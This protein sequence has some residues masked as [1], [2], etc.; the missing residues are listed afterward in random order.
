MTTSP[1]RF[2]FRIPI[3]DALGV[4]HDRCHHFDASADKPIRDVREAYFRAKRKL[5]DL[6]PEGLCTDDDDRTL[7]AEAADALRAAGC[8]LP[9][10]RLGF[11]SFDLATLVVW[12]LNQ[13]DP[14]LNA[15]LDPSP[16][17]LHFDGK[18]EQRR[19][20]GAIGYD[21]LG[22]PCQRP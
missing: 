5:P 12:F 14:T 1:R 4:G 6:C 16:E 18:D 3:G 9:G 21:L 17:T 13:G 20:I 2:R 10:G 22:G 19:H 8:P 15:T 7:S 11:G